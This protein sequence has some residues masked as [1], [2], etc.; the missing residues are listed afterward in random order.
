M[1]ITEAERK[2]LNLLWEKGS[3]STMQITEKL[4]DETG[5]SKHAVISFLKRM[6]T[7]GLVSYEE[8]G[9]AKYYTPLIEKK[10]IASKERN[11]FLHNFY[12]GKLGLMVSAMVEE[13]SLS[14]NDIDD[15]REILER[16]QNEKQ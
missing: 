9:R 6:E 10:D 1:N 13:N 4:E 16:L 15:L 7:K 5:W 12:H 8:R 2:I 11:T 3:L 14:P